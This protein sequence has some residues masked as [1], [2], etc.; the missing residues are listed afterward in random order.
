M[1]QPDN[2]CAEERFDCERSLHLAERYMQELRIALSNRNREGIHFAIDQL[3]QCLQTLY[4][5]GRTKK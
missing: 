3:R 1:T 4:I 5:S 2:W